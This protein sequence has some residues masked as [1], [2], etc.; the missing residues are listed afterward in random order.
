MKMIIC[1]IH[2]S[3]KK[4]RRLIIPPKNDSIEKTCT[5]NKLYVYPQNI[6]K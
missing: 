3:Y 4:P 5:N 6:K 1:R 2:N